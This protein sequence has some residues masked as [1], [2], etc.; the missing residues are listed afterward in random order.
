MSEKKA[1]EK[2]DEGKKAREEKEKAKEQP[3]RGRFLISSPTLYHAGFCMQ[4]PAWGWLCCKE[5]LM[6]G[7]D[8]NIEK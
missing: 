8:E 2:R 6:G 1:R 7:E 4:N 5:N 3:Q